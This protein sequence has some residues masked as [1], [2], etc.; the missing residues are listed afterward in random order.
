MVDPELSRPEGQEYDLDSMDVDES[1]ADYDAE[2]TN[3]KEAK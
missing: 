1:E 2:E 3:K